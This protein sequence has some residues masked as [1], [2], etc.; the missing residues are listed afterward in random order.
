M[1]RNRRGRITGLGSA[2][3]EHIMTNHDLEKMVD[4]TD[5]WI[6]S[7]TGIKER[8]ICEK[9]ESMS[10]L[11]VAAGRRALEMAGLGP[12]D[13]DL[14]LLGTV[15]P[16]HRLPSTACIVQKKL[17]LVNAAALDIVAA[18]AG[19]LHGLSIA[20]SFIRIGQYKRVM[21]I[22]A[23]KLSSCT[24]F[25]DRNTCVL[26]G[27]GAGAAVVEAS[28]GD[29]GILSTFL[30]SDGRLSELLWIPHGGSIAPPQSFHNGDG[31]FFITMSGSEVFRH[32]V[33]QMSDASLKALDM[34]G[35][36]S[37][38]VTVMVPHQANIRIMESAARR[39]GIPIE[40]VF[41]NIDKYGNTSA[42]SVPIALDE[43]VRSGRIKE[44]DIL[45]MA[46]FGGGLTWASATVKW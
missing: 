24:D 22:G 15:T 39:I 8:R 30:K 13:V 27:D 41:M 21:V 38:D 42:A 9:Y 3:P 4:T 43:V 35:L 7:R 6:Q 34:A 28:E 23:E 11:A 31:D 1:Y 26:F 20:N 16:D 44:G 40:R 45:L 19:F 17:G 5:E 25:T 32:A 10:D 18:C 29:R 33:R 36:K 2:V 37:E 12:K 46:A 14:L